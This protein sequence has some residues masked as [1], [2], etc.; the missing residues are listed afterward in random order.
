MTIKP[1]CAW[2]D[3]WVG[4]FIDRAKRRVYVFPLPMVG[5]VFEWGGRQSVS[6]KAS[7]ALDR[8]HAGEGG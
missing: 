6:P 7:N 4:V 5:L 8:G 2:Y 1:I 3:L